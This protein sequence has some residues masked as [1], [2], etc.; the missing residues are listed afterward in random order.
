MTACWVITFIIPWHPWS[1]IL[2]RSAT[3]SATAPHFNSQVTD[4]KQELRSGT[5]LGWYSQSAF[6][7]K[8]P[9]GHCLRP[10]VLIIEKSILREWEVCM[11]WGRFLIIRFFAGGT[12]IAKVDNESVYIIYEED[13]GLRVA[14]YMWDTNSQ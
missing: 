9:G 6:L 13:I 10:L 11:D 7:E 4:G 1:V 2:S 3:S 5:Q 8:S 14:S 12:M